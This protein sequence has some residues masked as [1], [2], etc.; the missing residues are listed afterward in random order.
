MTA[1]YCTPGTPQ[2]AFNFFD[3]PIYTCGS[4]GGVPPDGDPYI[5][6]IT[7]P[8]PLGPGQTYAFSADMKTSVGDFYVY[9]ANAAC[10]NVGELL[11][12]VHVTGNG[13]V[14]HQV[15]PVTG[16]YSH[17]IWVWQEGGEAVTMALCESGTCPTH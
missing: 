14:C 2:P 7:L 3:G 17:L 16:T 4:A 13:I 12:T 5:L 11:S 6:D 9:G 10:G 8:G 15:T 1:G